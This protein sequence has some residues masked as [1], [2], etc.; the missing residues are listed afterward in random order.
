MPKFQTTGAF[1]WSQPW[2]QLK[3]SSIQLWRSGKHAS[4]EGAGWYLPQ[5][6]VKPWFRSVHEQ[7]SQLGSCLS[8]RSSSQFCPQNLWYLSQGSVTINMK[9][10]WKQWLIKAAHSR[11]LKIELGNLKWTWRRWAWCH[12]SCHGSYSCLSSA[13]PA[14]TRDPAADSMA[15]SQSQSGTV[16]TAM[17]LKQHLCCHWKQS[18]HLLFPLLRQVVNKHW[19]DLS[20]WWHQQ[21]SRFSTALRI[22]F[23][24]K[25][26]AGINTSCS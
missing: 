19:S 15:S 24:K 9:K 6:S 13:P 8:L 10:S 5:V 17:A 2:Q 22:A 23:H 18:P 12:L 21:R 3:Y 4:V 25:A 26:E 16:Q 14:Q 20:A 1:L 11:A 7:V